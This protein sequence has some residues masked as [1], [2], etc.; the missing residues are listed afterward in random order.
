MAEAS[1]P[2]PFL[3]KAALQAVV[4]GLPLGACLVHELA[5]LVANQRLADLIGRPLAEVAGARNLADFA[6]PEERERAIGRSEARARGD[7]VIDDYELWAQLPSGERTLLRVMVSQFPAAGPGVVLAAFTSVRERD[8]PSAPDP[9]VL[10]RGDG[11]KKR[12]LVPVSQSP[13]LDGH[14][15]ENGECSFERLFGL[16]LVCAAR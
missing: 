6:A 8:R 7:A 9:R 14:G 11:R 4:D 15:A 10:R 13:P 1:Q 16:N 3:S 12:K 5:V 2:P